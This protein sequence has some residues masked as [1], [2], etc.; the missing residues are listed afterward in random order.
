MR[1]Q[2]TL[3]KTHVNFVNNTQSIKVEFV[4]EPKVIFD[5]FSFERPSYC[6]FIYIISDD[7]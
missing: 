6:K 5:T 7:S 3:Y 4:Q 1:D 2:A